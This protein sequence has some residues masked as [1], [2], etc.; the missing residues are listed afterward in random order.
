MKCRKC[1]SIF[2]DKVKQYK[3]IDD[4]YWE[5]NFKWIWKCPYCGSKKT[6]RFGEGKRWGAN[7]ARN[8]N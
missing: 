8:S 7:N 5:K 2:M 1:K 3:T 4:A 6:F